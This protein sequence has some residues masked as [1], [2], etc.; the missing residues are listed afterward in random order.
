MMQ[1]LV[2][3]DSAF[4]RAMLQNALEKW[5]YN[6]TTVDNIN[7][8]LQVILTDGIQFILTDWVMPGGDGPALCRKIRELGVDF[9]IYI[10]LITS[11]EGPQPL[12]DGM[13]AGADDF[14]HK[15]IQME[16]LRARIRAGARVLQLE[17][18]LHERN[19]KLA[20]LGDNLLAMQNIIQADLKVAERIQGKLL[21]ANLSCIL[22]VRMEAL[23]RPSSHVSG[24]IYNF[25]RLDDRRVGFY[26]IDVAGHGIAAAMMSLTLSQQL[27]PEIRPSSLITFGLHESLPGFKR[28]LPA[29]TVVARLNQQYQSDDAGTLYFTMIYGVIDT[30]TRCIDFCQ[31]GHPNPIYLPDNG[32]AQFIGD[33]GFP[34]GLTLLAE[35]ES[36]NL[37]CSQG[38]SLFFYSD[39][40]T[41]C[42]DENGQMFGEE[43]LLQLIEETK[44]L[45]AENVLPTIAKR[46]AAWRGNTK[47]DDDISLLKL[48]F[49]DMNCC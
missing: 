5:G 6:V 45:P 49:V 26:T 22:G 16:E 23:F 31:A 32:A 34:V 24:D 43:Q 7:D 46:I 18:S 35:Y 47:F 13:A 38:D 11:L 27:V 48:S 2:V 33:G 40:I 21:P 9:Y 25:F 14:V 10:I 17:R 20:E 15:P 8:A 30:V 37:Q 4:I 12:I 44:R 42:M 28:A 19:K 1:I 41:E 29:T 36:V 3:D 39:G